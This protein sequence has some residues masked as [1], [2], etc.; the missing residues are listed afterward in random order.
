MKRKSYL[1]AGLFLAFILLFAGCTQKNET[2][3]VSAYSPAVE[4]AVSSA[5]EASSVIEASSEES[6]ISSVAE[7]SSETKSEAAIDED[8]AYYT[9]DDV[10]AYI[11]AYSHLP[12]NYLTKKEAQ[13][14]GWVANKGNLWDV[15]YGKCIGGDKFGNREGHLPKVSGRTYYECDVN[16][17]GGY[18]SDER[19]VYTTDGYVYYTEDHYN[20]FE[21]LYGGY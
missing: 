21:Q 8:E 4:S 11:Y 16:Y 7:V 13:N 20:T 9:K 15:A 5:A 1:F 18:R 2:A 14:L 19:L 10:A 3:E 12:S 17:Y 6:E